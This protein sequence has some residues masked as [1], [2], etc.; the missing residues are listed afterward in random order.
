MYI[1][2]NEITNSW[3]WLRLVEWFKKWNWKEKEKIKKPDRA[4]DNV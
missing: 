1:I 4:V 2:K 3:I